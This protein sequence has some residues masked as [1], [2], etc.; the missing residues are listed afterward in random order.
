MSS[1]FSEDKGLWALLSLEGSQN[2]FQI[3][4]ILYLNAYD[5]FFL[6]EMGRGVTKV[7][8]WQ[9]ENDE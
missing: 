8:Y 7:H 4:L 2:L 6:Q 5:F 3:Y 9:C 1:D